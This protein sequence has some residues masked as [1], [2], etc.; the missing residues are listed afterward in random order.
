MGRLLRGSFG[1]PSF[2]ASY[3]N[4][5]M[6]RT[7]VFVDAG[8]LFAQGSFAIAGRRL[9]RSEIDFNA[10]GA[11]Q[12]IES[13]VREASGLPLLRIYWYDGTDRGPTS[14]HIALAELPNIKL[15]LGYV[16][17]V[18]EQKE[19][20]SLIITDMITLARNK[21]IS[22]AI[23]LS[24][25]EDLRVGVQQAQEQGVRVHLLGIKPSR[26]SQSLFLLQE[27]DTTHEWQEAD[28]AGFMA[29][30]SVHENEVVSNL[31]A[32]SVTEPADTPQTIEQVAQSVAA[33]IPTGDLEAL[34][35]AFESTHQIPK[36]IDGKLLA[37]AKDK[38]AKMLNPA[39]KKQAREALISAC[40]Q[41]LLN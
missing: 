33:E 4:S 37:R 14:T 13:Y 26:G 8:Y 2:L 5:I 29:V 10:E 9:A 41:L 38:L 31:S 25:D 30:R 40:R 23:L 39:E 16:N 19:V 21:A 18:G 28:L 17:S 35:T 1:N 32:E 7:A 24:G 15:R 22:D 36:E 3:S 11:R 20:D 6:D 12:A 34:I 27:S